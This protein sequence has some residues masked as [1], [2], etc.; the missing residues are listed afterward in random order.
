MLGV[1]LPDWLDQETLRNVA[2]GALVGLGIGVVLVL[3]L[4]KKVVTKVLL[5]VVLVGAGFAIYNQREELAT[6]AT[7]CECAFFGMD[8]ALPTAAADACALVNRQ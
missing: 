3:W 1:S 6:C 5:V 7:D 2:L 4:A 8:V